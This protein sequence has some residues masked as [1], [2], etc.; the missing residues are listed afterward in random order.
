MTGRTFLIGLDGATFDVLDP[1]M[2]DGTMPRLSEFVNHGVRSPLRTVVPALTPPAWTSLMTGRSPGHHG[3]FDFFSKE[4]PESHIFHVSNAHDVKA[5]T[6]WSMADRKGLRST[7]LNFP[8]TFPAP[9]FRGN[10]VPGWMPWRQLR[11]G[12]R[13]EGLYDRIKRLPDFEAKEL[14]MDLSPE[15]KA[16]QGCRPEELEAWV[17]FYVR[18]ERQWLQIVEMLEEEDPSEL[19]AILFDGVD[20]IQHLCWRFIDPRYRDV[21]QSDWAQRIRELCLGY[22][23]QLDDVLSRIFELA[24]K[25]S[26]VVIASDHGFGAQTGTFFINAWLEKKGYL[27]WANENTPQTAGSEDLG[28]EQLARHV[29]LLDWNKTRAYVPTPSGNGIYFARPNGGA[30]VTESEYQELRSRLVAELAEVKDDRGEPVVSQIWTRDEVF[31]GPCEALA[32]DVTLSLSDGGLVS[33]LASSEVYRSRSEPIGAH[34]PEGVFLARGPGLRERKSLHELS[35]L[36]VA[37]LILYSL[38]LPVPIDLEGRVPREA[39]ETGWFDGRP[40]ASGDSSANAPRSTSQTR[41][42]AVALSKDDE[43]RLA[44]HLRALGYIN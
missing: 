2:Q 39:F 36:D 31:S 3:I 32:P 41:R 10:V 16:V 26:T 29:Y 15:A 5:E 25:D 21:D 19:T 37:P 12:C 24:S 4:S 17:S 22:Y 28:I 8:L 11:L 38:G 33:I 20:K 23:R 6:I 27:S 42:A 34:R 40:V 9:P 13:P 18:R 43:E 35:I 30:G 44:S 1:L 7:V 14:A